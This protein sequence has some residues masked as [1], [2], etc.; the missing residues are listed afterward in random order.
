MLN[1]FRQKKN[2]TDVELASKLWEFCI[3]MSQVFQ[4]SV[5]PS[6]EE[7]GLKLSKEEKEGSIIEIIN[8]NLWI[9]S[10]AL[11]SE[12]DVLENLHHF[13]AFAMEKDSERKKPKQ[14]AEIMGNLI[15]I[16]KKYYNSWNDESGGVQMSLS[17][18]ILQ[19]LFNNGG[20]DRKFL[21]AFAAYPVNHYVLT[22]IQTT[23]DLRDK[24]R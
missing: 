20:P 1:L 4:Q 22:T 11:S 8:L 21:N 14:Q 3:D 24:L 2:L 17:I 19:Q 18:E 16:Y 9:I 13:Y 15:E 12:K 23:L 5:I 6:I 10:K 7:A